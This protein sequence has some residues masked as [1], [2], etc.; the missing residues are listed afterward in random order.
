MTGAPSAGVIVS[1]SQDCGKIS[2]AALHD[3]AALYDDTSLYDDSALNDNI[4]SAVAVKVAGDNAR[5]I[6][7]GQ[8][9]GVILQGKGSVAVSVDRGEGRH[10]CRPSRPR[11]RPCHRR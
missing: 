10:C 3:D 1:E 4:G 2:N 6:Q 7:A 11:G 8:H 5:S 9:I